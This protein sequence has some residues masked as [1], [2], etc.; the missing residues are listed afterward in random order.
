MDWYCVNTD[1]VSKLR[2]NDVREDVLTGSVGLYQ[3]LRVA[4]QDKTGIKTAKSLVCE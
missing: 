4:C 2:I 1:V 3:I